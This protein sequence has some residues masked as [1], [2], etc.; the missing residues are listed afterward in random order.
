MAD[1]IRAILLI[2]CDGDPH[3]LLATGSCGAMPPIVI[4]EIAEES[5]HLVWS[6][7]W[8]PRDPDCFA[9][10]PWP[11]AALVLVWNGEIVFEGCD[12]AARRVNTTRHYNSA[13]SGRDVDDV[14]MLAKMWV[15][16]FG[17]QIEVIHG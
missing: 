12:R 5:P 14:K 13:W 16:V 17:G 11:H 7:E 4:Q 1:S 10:E 8:T 3:R 15:H 2:P 6:K 9:L